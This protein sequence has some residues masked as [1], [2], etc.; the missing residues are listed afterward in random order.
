MLA[1][2]LEAIVGKKSAS[3]QVQENPLMPFLRVDPAGEDATK[4]LLRMLLR[5]PHHPTHQQVSS[6]LTQSGWFITAQD[7][8]RAYEWFRVLDAQIP[9]YIDMATAIVALAN[10]LSV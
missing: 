9:E 4:D 2:R 6:S 10:Y 7:Y 8:H 5:L 1:K 3:A